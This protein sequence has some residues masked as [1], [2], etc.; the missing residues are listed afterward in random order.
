[1]TRDWE[2]IDFF[3]DEAAEVLKRRPIE[4]ARALRSFLLGYAYPGNIRELR[5]IIY[6]L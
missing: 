2:T 1:M 6:R 5:N 3:S 4:M